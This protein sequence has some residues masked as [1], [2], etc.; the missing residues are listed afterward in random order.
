MTLEKIIQALESERKTAE[1]TIARAGSSNRN[2]SDFAQGQERAYA[3][4]LRL[5]R[6]YK[7]PVQRSEQDLAIERAAAEQDMGKDLSRF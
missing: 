2:R 3:H 1:T 5:I 4:A 7:E 6:E